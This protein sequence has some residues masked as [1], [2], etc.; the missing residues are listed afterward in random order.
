[1][2]K[3]D[4]NRNTLENFTYN[5]SE[6]NSSKRD[7]PVRNMPQLKRQLLPDDMTIFEKKARKA[8]FAQQHKKK[9]QGFEMNKM[10]MT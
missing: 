2:P 4:I 1:M 8:T 7:L 6:A 3:I 5:P 9:P 10:V